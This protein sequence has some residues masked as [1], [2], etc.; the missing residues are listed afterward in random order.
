VCEVRVYGFDTDGNRTSLTRRGANADGSCAATGGSATQWAYDSAGRLISGADGAGSYTYDA[1]G[2]ATT[3][4]A[5][6][7][8]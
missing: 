8:A 3:L 2:R 5:I 7:T 1:L 6:D 4:P